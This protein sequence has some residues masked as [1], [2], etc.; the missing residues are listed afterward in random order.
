MFD[1]LLKDTS[2][3]VSDELVDIVLTQA[4]CPRVIDIFTAVLLP[5]ASSRIRLK[6]WIVEE[7]P[8]SSEVFVPSMHTDNMIGSNGIPEDIISSSTVHPVPAPFST[9]ELTNNN[10]SEGGSNQKL[11]LLSRGNAINYIIGRAFNCYLLIITNEFRLCHPVGVT[12]WALLFGLLL[13]LLTD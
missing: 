3:V 8:A 12:G 6:L 4:D 9:N 11:I 10:T 1:P 5:P 7:F 13:V 2:R